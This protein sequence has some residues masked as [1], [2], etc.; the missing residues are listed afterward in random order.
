MDRCSSERPDDDM[1]DV[2]VP[3]ASIRD[4]VETL[5]AAV[6][7]AGPSWE[8]VPID[9]LAGRDLA[10][11]AGGT[12][13]VLLPDGE[14]LGFVV[15]HPDGSD[16]HDELIRVLLRMTASLVAAERSGSD[17]RQRAAAAERDARIDPL[18]E[19]LN[20]RGWDD[21][22][23][24]EAARMRRHDRWATLLLIDIDRL[25]ET[26]D[27]QGHLAGDLL[28]RRTSLAIRSAVR[29]EDVVARMGGDE[30]AVLV[31]E[32]DAASVDRV[33]DRIR[34]ALFDVGVAASVGT[35][36][37]EPGASLD[38][39]LARADRDM[40]AAKQRRRVHAS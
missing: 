15:R 30:F 14:V 3:Y 20:R 18:T 9:S 16:E 24:R 7:R 32:S 35:A 12:W 8:F 21:A 1:R 4:A 26:N 2:D 5:V 27:T 39:A 10:G 19:L 31:V 38:D 11:T 29:D 28:I 6:E 17:A 23:S 13:P 22:L 34:R 37:V 33:G 25:K 40:Y 36:S